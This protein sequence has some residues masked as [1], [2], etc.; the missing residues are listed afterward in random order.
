ME[1]KFNHV[2]KKGPS[3]REVI[4]KDIGKIKWCNETNHSKM[5][6]TLSSWY[7]QYHCSNWIRLC[8]EETGNKN[9]MDGNLINQTVQQNTL[10]PEYQSTAEYWKNIHYIRVKKIKTK[11]LM[12]IKLNI[13]MRVYL[14]YTFGYINQIQMGYHSFCAQSCLLW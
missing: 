2:S 13:I 12:K 14:L 11:S 8:S 1:F 5:G 6:S 9:T 7:S 10:Q 4:L 3:A